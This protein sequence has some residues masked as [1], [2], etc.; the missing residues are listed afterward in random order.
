MAR[1]CKPVPGDKIVGFI[2]S[3]RGVT[4]HRHD[5][6]NA[7]HYGSTGDERLVE[8]SWGRQRDNTYPVDVEVMVYDRQG[9]LRDIASILANEKI[10]V[11][12][13]STLSDKKASIGRIRLTLEIPNVA[14]LSRVLTRIDRLPNV[15]AVRRMVH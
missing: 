15:T 13:I 12:A 11:M 7:L 10:N 8:V 2:T 14:T 9:L 1:C 3:G 5:C 6:P 4:V